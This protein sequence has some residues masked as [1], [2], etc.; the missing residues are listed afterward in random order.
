MKEGEREQLKTLNNSLVN[1]IDKVHD[2]EMMVKKLCVENAKLS[3]KCKKGSPE[4]D[5]RA[6]YE[7]ELRVCRLYLFIHFHKKLAS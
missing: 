6:I 1:Y 5:I 2:L 4:I 3:K 7:A